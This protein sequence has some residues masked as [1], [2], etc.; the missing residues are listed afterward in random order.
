MSTPHATPRRMARGT[1]KAPQTRRVR[2]RGDYDDLPPSRPASAAP[3]ADVPGQ[4]ARI[5]KKLDQTLKPKP[6]ASLGSGLGRLAGNFLGQGDLGASAGDAIQKWLGYGDYEL[7]TNSLIPGKDTSKSSSIP[8]FSRDGRRGIRLTEREF[9]GDIVAGTAGAFNLQS[10]RINPADPATFPWL[11]TVACEFEEWEPLGII[12]EYVPTSSDYN[13]SSQALGSV[14]MAT[15]YDPTDSAYPN[16]FVME[17]ADYACSTRPSNGQ[18]HGIECD[19]KERG[20][21]S[22]YTAVSAPSVDLRLCDLGN[23][24]IATQGSSSVSTLGEL[25]VS[26]DIALYKKQLLGG[27]VGNSILC[28]ASSSSNPTN[29][30]PCGFSSTTFTKAGTMSVTVSRSGPATL[31]SFPTN[32]VTGCY[33][34][35]L[36]ASAATGVSLTAGTIATNDATKLTLV[37]TF[38][39]GGTGTFASTNGAAVPLV[40][41]RGAFRILASGAQITVADA[42]LQY[43]GAPSSVQV[44]IMQIPDLPLPAR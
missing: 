17:Q 37:A 1:N 40:S 23:F 14:I 19:L 22:F 36:T 25:W 31:Y 4:L 16:K 38:T 42:A 39:G 33:E 43:T 32:L 24:Q 8:T 11:S 29:A 35:E 44:R 15:D 21:R 5:E 3:R 10:F 20:V 41:I 27:Q 26:Y 9:L 2:G 30:D 34:V 6:A 12:F 13:G 7:V 28:F 18:R